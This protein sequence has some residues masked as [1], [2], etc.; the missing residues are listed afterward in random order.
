MSRA[1]IVG[2]IAYNSEET[3]RKN[4]DVYIENHKEICGFRIVINV[5]KI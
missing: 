3:C 4:A 5:P 1:L 2:T